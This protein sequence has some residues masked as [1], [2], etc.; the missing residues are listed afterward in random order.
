MKTKLLI[1]L[2]I[3]VSQACFAQVYLDK[4]TEK[5]CTCLKNTSDKDGQEVWQMELGLCIIEAAEPYKKELMKEHKI[6]LNKIDTQG[7][8][9]GRLIGVRMASAC[10]ETLLNI[11]KKGD[12][13]N[14]DKTTE[15]TYEGQVTAVDDSKFIEFSVKD[16]TGKINKFY[17]FTFIESG[18]ELS[19]TYKNLVGKSVEI[20]YITQEFF[21]ARIAEYRPFYI[22]QKL[23]LK[24]K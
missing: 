2:L 22:V 17:W 1:F 5:A 20:T 8:E 12:L 21:D 19:S 3:T 16:E 6:D 10:P 18:V 4:I 13:V 11:A 15:K 9:L 14:E 7:E 23:E 24:D